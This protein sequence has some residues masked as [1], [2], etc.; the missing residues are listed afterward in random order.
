MRVLGGKTRA[1]FE[2]NK[3]CNKHPDISVNASVPPEHRRVPFG[4]MIYVADGPSDVPG[5][6]LLGRFGGH[7]APG[8][9]RRRTGGV[10]ATRCRIRTCPARGARVALRRCGQ[11]RP[12][13]DSRIRNRLSRAPPRVGVG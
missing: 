3:G 2:I 11:R 10:V 8:S 1:F 12:G 7:R 6:S 13:G 4:N 9:P 5:V